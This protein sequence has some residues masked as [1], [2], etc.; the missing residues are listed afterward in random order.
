MADSRQAQP[1]EYATCPNCGDRIDPDLIEELMME[2]FNGVIGD[3][4]GC[5]HEL[6]LSIAGVIIDDLGESNDS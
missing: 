1:L 4:D 6:N 5:K 3:C 2:P